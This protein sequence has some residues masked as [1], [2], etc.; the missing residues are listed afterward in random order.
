[1]GKLL[2]QVELRLPLYSG[3]DLIITGGVLF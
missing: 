2:P 3:G 1:M